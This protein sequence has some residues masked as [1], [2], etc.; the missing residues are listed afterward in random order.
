MCR[1]CT[2][3]AVAVNSPHCAHHRGVIHKL[4]KRA[5]KDG[6]YDVLQAALMDL[7]VASWLFEVSAF[8]LEGPMPIGLKDIDWDYFD[9]MLQ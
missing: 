1:Y 6:R 2:K 4:R 7:E 8:L 3:Q 9:N 5:V